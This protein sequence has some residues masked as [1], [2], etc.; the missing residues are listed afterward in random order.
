MSSQH[1]LCPG[2]VLA[3][4]TVESLVLH[5]E[6]RFGFNLVLVLSVDLAPVR[7]EI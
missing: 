2:G 5:V 3:R 1:E 7:A 4:F 6:L